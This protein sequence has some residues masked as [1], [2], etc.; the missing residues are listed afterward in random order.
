MYLL[1]H[2]SSSDEQNEDNDR[3][4]ENQQSLEYNVCTL[5]QLFMLS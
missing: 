2:G 5:E 1:D 4:E 3:N